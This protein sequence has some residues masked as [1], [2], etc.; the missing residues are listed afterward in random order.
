[1]HTKLLHRYDMNSFITGPIAPESNPPIHP[2]WYL[3][4]NFKISAIAIGTT[5]TV[6][7]TSS[8][9]APATNNFVVGQR[10][11]FHIPITYGT[12]ELNEK[13]GFVIAKPASNQ[14]VVDIDSTKFTQFIASPAYGPTPPQISA[15]GDI[16][17]GQINPLPY[18]QKTFIPG[19][20]IDVSPI[21]QI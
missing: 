10:V 17:S 21:N 19:S 9:S 4:S 15:I 16:N 5:T 6:T 20:F 14:V 12:R 8:V 13:T 2:L 7:T 11:R 18:K 3:P 1:M